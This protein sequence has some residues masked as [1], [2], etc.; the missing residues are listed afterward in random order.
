M[1]DA[2]E[3]IWIV[4]ALVSLVFASAGV[5][6]AFNDFRS[7]RDWFGLFLSMLCL[8]ALAKFWHLM[9]VWIKYIKGL[10]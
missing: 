7:E 2:F 3:I 4:I 10:M 5:L 9:Y 8:V 6:W 1:I